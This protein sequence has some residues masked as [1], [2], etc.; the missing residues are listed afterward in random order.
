MHSKCGFCGGLQWEI[1]EE[2]PDNSA[3]KVFFVRCKSCKVPI[4]V[5]DYYD[6]HSKLEKIENTV[7]VLG[8]SVTGALGVID[9][10]VRKLL[11]K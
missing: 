9:A 1:D 4:G 5:M 6:T 11:H 8:N 3:Y 10:N 2:S 7:K